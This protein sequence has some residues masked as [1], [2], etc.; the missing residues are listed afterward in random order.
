M[1][2]ANAT[3]HTAVQ[4]LIEQRLDAIDRALLGLLPR[5][6]RLAAVAQVETRIRE[7]VAASPASAAGLHTPTQGLTIPDSAFSNLATETPA[8]LPHPQFFGLAPGSGLPSTQKRRSRLALS[9]GVMGIL[10]LALLLMVPVTYFIVEALGEVC[11]ISLLGAHAV[12]VA[13]GGVAAVGLGI[14]ALV[15]LSRHREQLVGHGWAIAGLCAGPLPMLLGCAAVLFFGLQLGVSQFF[16]ASEPAAVA[17]DADAPTGSEYPVGSGPVPISVSPA[18]A[19]VPQSDFCQP[20]VQPAGLEAPAAAT[21]L[22]A[23]EP[24]GV[25]AT[26]P[27]CPATLPK[28]EPAQRAEPQPQTDHQPVP[29]IEPS[30]EPVS[31]PESAPTIST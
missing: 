23:V 2:T 28:P 16:T 11:A 31:M 13:V 26:P 8:F 24:S 21:Q 12:A 6:D 3:P 25:V 14:G 4:Q 19:P 27:A 30:V 22:P 10:A 15:S 7:V 29:R 9:A 20:A 17:I 1:S 5:S 18:M